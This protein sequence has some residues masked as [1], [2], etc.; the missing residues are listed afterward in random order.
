MEKYGKRETVNV[1]KLS[2]K[3]STCPAACS[4]SPP[5][6]F[7]QLDE[8]PGSSFCRQQIPTI[9]FCGLFDR[10]YIIKHFDPAASKNPPSPC[11]GQPT[12]RRISRLWFCDTASRSPSPESRH[13]GKKLL[14]LGISRPHVIE[15]LWVSPENHLHQFC[16][17]KTEKTQSL[18]LNPRTISIEWETAVSCFWLVAVS[19]PQ[20]VGNPC[21]S[22][23]FSS[24]HPSPS[25]SPTFAFW[26]DHCSNSCPTERPKSSWRQGGEGKLVL[27]PDTAWNTQPFSAFVSLAAR[28]RREMGHW[29]IPS[30]YTSMSELEDMNI[31]MG[32]QK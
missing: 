10:R 3:M 2:T 18:E 22:L 1:T 6:L 11:P 5:P 32:N 9:K 29:R 14:H 24:P 23:L 25:F 13:I 17:E 30:F 21:W 4:M 16:T 20:G 12:S 26:S 19:P 15:Q 27:P 8:E 31:V 7:L 28:E